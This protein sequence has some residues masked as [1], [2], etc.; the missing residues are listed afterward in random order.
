MGE[1]D[2]VSTKRTVPYQASTIPARAIVINSP[3]NLPT[4][5]ALYWASCF[6][7]SFRRRSGP[8]PLR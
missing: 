8:G 4:A 2:G 7:S 3:I 1:E 5:A 6:F